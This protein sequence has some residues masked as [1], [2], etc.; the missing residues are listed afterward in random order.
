MSLLSQ[1]KL[2][3]GSKIAKRFVESLLITTDADMREAKEKKRKRGK[4]A[5]RIKESKALQ[6]VRESG[7]A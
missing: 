5:E 3:K 2:S 1:K 4:Q 6:S 7:N